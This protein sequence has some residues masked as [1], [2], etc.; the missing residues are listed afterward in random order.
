[1][2]SSP[3][4]ATAVITFL[5]PPVDVRPA[6]AASVRTPVDSAGGAGVATWVTDVPSSSTSPRR[7]DGS[8]APATTA[9]RAVR[10]CSPPGSPPGGAENAEELPALTCLA[11]LAQRRP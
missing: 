4:A 6:R 5:A 8:A 2:T 9:G 7:A 10:S 1:M 11:D 3:V